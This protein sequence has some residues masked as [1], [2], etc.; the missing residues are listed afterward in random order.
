VRRVKSSEALNSGIQPS[1][2]RLPM[3]AMRCNKSTAIR[4]I[5]EMKQT[6]VPEIER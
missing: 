3:N 2:P 5:S 4:E 6:S 1:Q